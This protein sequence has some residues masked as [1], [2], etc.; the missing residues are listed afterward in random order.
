MCMF[1]DSAYA[2][3]PSDFAITVD[4]E[5]VPELHTDDG[6]YE[7]IPREI[8]FP[9]PG[10]QDT[11]HVCVSVQRAGPEDIRV[12]AKAGSACIAGTMP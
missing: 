11:A 4:G 2:A 10:H 1:V 9:L 3:I 5:A 6:P 12:S 8:W 7:N